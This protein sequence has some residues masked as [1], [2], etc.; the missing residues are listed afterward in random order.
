VR[1]AGLGNEASALA[2]DFCARKRRVQC[3]A[4]YVC[5]LFLVH[6]IDLS[7]NTIESSLTLMY[8]K[9]VDL[10]FVYYNGEIHIVEPETEESDYHAK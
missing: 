2:A 10:G 6:H 5:E 3:P 1:G 8:Q 7:W 4:I 9:L